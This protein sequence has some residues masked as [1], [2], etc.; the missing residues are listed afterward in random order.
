MSKKCKKHTTKWKEKETQSGV[1][2]N[3]TKNTG[4]NIKRQIRTHK[5]RQTQ[6][7]TKHTQTHTTKREFVGKYQ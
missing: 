3:N 2:K 4:T 6:K 5:F 1:T 7:Q